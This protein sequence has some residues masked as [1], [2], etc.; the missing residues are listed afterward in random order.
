MHMHRLAPLT[1]FT[2]LL[3]L[4]HHVAHVLNLRLIL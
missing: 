1:V 3:S 2:L 4:E